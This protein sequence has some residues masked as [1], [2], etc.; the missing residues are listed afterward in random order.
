MGLELRNRLEA[1]LELSL[2]GTLV[3]NYPTIGQLAPHLGRLVQIPLDG[4]ESGAAAE[5]CMTPED[6]E[7]AELLAEL[8]DLSPEEV[9]RLLTEQDG[10]EASDG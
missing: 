5:S 7:L 1:A 6:A 10:R 3:Y 2:P 8:D 9:R 4:D